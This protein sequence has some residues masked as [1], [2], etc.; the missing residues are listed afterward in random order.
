MSHVKIPHVTCEKTYIH[1]DRFT[2]NDNIHG[3]KIE[4]KQHN[5]I[6]QRKKQ[7]SCDKSFR[8]TQQD[9]CGRLMEVVDRSR[10]NTRTPDQMGR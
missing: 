7:V 2:H 3:N 8:D 10:D 9:T 4:Y 1:D 6:K 5:R